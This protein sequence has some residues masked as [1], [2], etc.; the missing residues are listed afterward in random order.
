M[1]RNSVT[2]ITRRPRVAVVGAGFG[3]LSLVRG[4]RHAP[5]EVI[6]VD[7]H[8]YHL[9][10]PLLYQVATALL[11]PAEIAHP[12]RSI[13]RR[14]RNVHVRMGRLTAVHL[15]ERSIET[16]TGA[17]GYDHLVVAV[18]SVNNFFGNPSVEEHAYPL[19][20]LDEAVALRNHVLECFERAAV[21]ADSTRRRRL[22]TIAVVGAGPTGVECSGAFAELSTLV[23]T[24]DFRDSDLERVD[25]E[26]LEAAPTL[27][28]TFAPSL[29]QAAR[30]TLERKRVAVRLRTGVSELSPAGAVR[31]QDGGTLDAATVVWTAGVK[32]AHAAE[33]LGVEPVQ[34]NRV[35]VDEWM[36]VAGRGEVHAIG[37]VAA[38]QGH[39]GPHPMLAPVA[40]Q[41]G[42]HVAR[43]ITAQARGL[44][45][46]GPFRYRDKG[47]MA[48]IGRNSGIAQIGRL[49]FSGFIGWLM[50]LFV[51][52]V[53]IV[54][55]RSRV[56]VLLNW[57]WNY[58][59]FDRPVRLIT[60]LKKPLRDEEE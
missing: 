49:H 30:R 44:P 11:D 10:T 16:T 43:Q 6:L 26:L 54:S 48:T 15:D 38:V 7:Q 34:G 3:G 27:L 60:A 13:L 28:A 19:K 23:L 57:A 29:Q 59:F 17:V 21:T 46:P 39:G 1:Q 25:I 9:F 18:G 50:W 24:R 56:V 45:G 51:H 55:F 20:S 2:G 35:P 41:Q 12:I 36:R 40:I 32:A 22:E 58:V 8:N 14:Q 31:L 52:L 53:Q 47:T 5:V 4:L 33:L 37:D 42:D